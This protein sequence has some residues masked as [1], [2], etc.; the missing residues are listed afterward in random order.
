M[1]WPTDGSPRTNDSTTGPVSRRRVLTAVG[2]GLLAAAAGCQA[3]DGTGS[4]TGD[5]PDATATPAFDPVTVDI[6][7]TATYL[8]TNNDAAGDTTPMA[9]ADQPF[10]PGDRITLERLGE[11]DNGSP[12]GTAGLGMHAVFSGSAD[13]LG[14]SQRDRVPDAIDVGPDHVTSPTYYGSLPTSIPADFLVSNNDGSQTSVTVDVPD[15]ATHLFVA[16]KDNLYEDNSVAG[17]Q[18][19]V[20]ISDGSAGSP[21]TPTTP[22]ATPAMPAEGTPADGSEAPEPDVTVDL[23]PTATYLRTSGD[24]AADAAPI[25]L[26]EYDIAAGDSVTLSVQGSY[27]NGAGD[28]R[29]TVA[30]FSGSS[31]LAA[32]DQQNRVVDAIDAGIDVDTN[33]TFYGSQ[34]TDIPED[35]AVADEENF[36]S[37]TLP[38]PEG[39]T[40]LF[41]SPDDNLFNDNA[42]N[43]Y[44]LGLTTY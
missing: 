36:A 2:T 8:R 39:A 44:R 33:T 29:S 12:G 21:A 28:R 26:S 23:D 5:G 22:E 34:P 42:S 43:D 18:F 31:T 16:A 11:F 6:P 24:N 41:V 37:V 10:G 1:R 40:H 3:D 35:F 38:V 19:A 4:P 15:G 13:L 32:S 17:D 14:Q 30:V 27:D 20:R 7:P 9:L 25:A